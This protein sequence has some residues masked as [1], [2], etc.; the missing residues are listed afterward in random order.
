MVYGSML[1]A[2]TGSRT[3]GSRGK[4]LSRVATEYMQLLY[5]MSKARAK[6]CAYIDEVQGV[7]GDLVLLLAG[8]DTFELEGGSYTKDAH[9][10][11]GPFIFCL[12]IDC[13]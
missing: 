9:I 13:D 5:H 4:H 11:L 7:R 3:Q 10:R 12:F 2:E 6:K 8:S 1:L